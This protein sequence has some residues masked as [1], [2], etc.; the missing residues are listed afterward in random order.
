MTLPTKHVIRLPANVTV[1]VTK[2]SGKVCLINTIKLIVLASFENESSTFSKS[3][4]WLL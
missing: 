2:V 1:T 4:V 3:V